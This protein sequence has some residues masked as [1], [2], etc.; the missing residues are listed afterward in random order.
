MGHGALIFILLHGFGARLVIIPEA[1]HVPHEE[2][3]TAF[4]QTVDGFFYAKSWRSEVGVRSI[5]Q[6]ERIAP[7]EERHQSVLTMFSSL[8]LIAL[9][10][11]SCDLPAPTAKPVELASTT[12][13]MIAKVS[14]TATSLEASDTPV[15]PASPTGTLTPTPAPDCDRAEF[16]NDVTYPDNVGVN[17]DEAITK[18]WRIKNVGS[19]TW[20]AAYKLVF[21]RGDQM[22]GSS[23][24]EVIST[25]VSPGAEVD[26]SI[27]LNAPAINGIHWG[28]W[29]INNAAGKPLLKADGKPQELSILINITNGRGGK[30]TA[31]RTWSYTFAGTKCT[32]A[33]QYEIMTHIY[34]DGPVGVGYTW[35]VTNGVLSV[36]SQNYAFDSAGS[37][38]VVTQINP[39][40]ADPNNVKVTLTANGISSSFTICP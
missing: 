25:S 28:V 29:Q 18:T 32:N 20:D 34:V 17:A 16:V 11:S 15:A 37:L 9:M 21:I 19:C 36:V 35:S 4:M 39:P 38:E 30:V 14:P 5:K 6:T 3:P 27:K 22:N 40:F 13:E 2:Q 24:A 10:L 1:G 23:P 33:V 12:P 26:L 31:V 8:L 7:M